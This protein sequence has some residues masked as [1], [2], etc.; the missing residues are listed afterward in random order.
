MQLKASLS[1]SLPYHFASTVVPINGMKTFG[2][3]IPF[4]QDWKYFTRHLKAKIKISHNFQ[5]QIQNSELL[6]GQTQAPKGISF[7]INFMPAFNRVLLL[8]HN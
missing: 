6:M 4:V 3:V 5:A 8:F 1:K 7:F 2:L